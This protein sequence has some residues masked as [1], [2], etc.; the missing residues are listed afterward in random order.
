MSKKLNLDT[1]CIQGGWKPNKGESRV[2]PIFQ[3]TTLK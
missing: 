2:L 1:I 3:S